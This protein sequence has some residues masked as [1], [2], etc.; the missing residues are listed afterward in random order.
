[1]S[2][3]HN[4]YQIPLPSR[5]N[6]DDFLDYYRECPATEPKSNLQCADKEGPV[7]SLQKLK[8]EFNVCTLE[9]SGNSCA[10]RKQM[11]QMPVL[12]LYFAPG[13]LQLFYLRNS[14]PILSGIS[15]S[16][17]G[18]I[19]LTNNLS[20]INSE[21]RRIAPLLHVLFNFFEDARLLGNKAGFED[22]TG[23][24][25]QEFENLN[26]LFRCTPESTKLYSLEAAELAALILIKG[27]IKSYSE[28]LPQKSLALGDGQ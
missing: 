28:S 1:M 3:N 6:P 18:Q 8:N 24:M 2:I 25:I 4:I 7:W 22:R 14:S 19:F 15:A 9:N 11:G 10:I 21:R 23:M 26:V 5:A 16:V 27:F 17:T 13:I 20:D 12:R